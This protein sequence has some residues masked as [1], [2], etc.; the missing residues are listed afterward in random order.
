MTIQIFNN[1]TVWN[2]YP[3]VSASPQAVDKWMQAC[4]DVTNGDVDSKTYHST[5]TYRYYVNPRGKGIPPGGSLTVTLPLYTQIVRSPDPTNRNKDQYINWWAGGQIW[6][7]DGQGNDPP[8]ALQDIFNIDRATEIKNIFGPSLPFNKMCTD[9]AGPSGTKCQPVEVFQSTTGNLSNRQPAQLLEYTL[10]AVNPGPNNRQGTVAFVLNVKN[11]DIDLSYVNNAYL[12]AALEPVN[13]DLPKFAQIG[14]IGTT[15]FVGT[16]KDALRRFIKDYKNNDGTPGWPQ[17]LNTKGTDVIL[18]LASP[19][20][21]FT[22]SIVGP[23]PDVRP[24]ANNSGPLKALKNNWLKC[25][26][27]DSDKRAICVSMRKV[28]ALF[29][30][31]YQNYKTIFSKC[32]GTMEPNSDAN[33]IAHVYGYTPFIAGCPANANLIENTPSFRTYDKDNY[34]DVRATYDRLQEWPDPDRQTGEFDPWVLLVHDKKYINA[35]NAYAYSVDDALGNLQADGTGFIVAVAGT[36]GLP[37]PN[38]AGPPINVTVGPASGDKTVTFDKVGICTDDASKFQPVNPSFSSWALSLSDKSAYAKC[39]ITLVDSNKKIYK[40]KLTGPPPYDM[41][42]PSG[43][44]K[45]TKES[46]AFIDCSVSPQATIGWCQR[47]WAFT[48]TGK[49]LAHFANGVPPCVAASECAP[50]PPCK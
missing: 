8:K 34:L 6:L 36:R 33:M 22:S 17:Y 14:W 35:P 4:F 12:P 28:K 10:G 38:P 5:G 11:L 47:A 41:S 21:V 13:P 24:N 1:T 49:I 30:A 31:N 9:G 7:F 19:L 45:C 26:D 46:H 20:E 16:F 39:P 2:L 43:K 50:Q 32:T 29:V 23:N 40:F 18:K 15:Q 48:R 44:E 25:T 27:D 37:N 3:V 42:Q